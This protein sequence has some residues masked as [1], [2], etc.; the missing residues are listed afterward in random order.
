MTNR[1]FTR[2]RQLCLDCENGFKI[3]GK[4]TAFR[5]SVL[6]E[7][8][9]KLPSHCLYYDGPSFPVDIVII[10]AVAVER[11][12]VLAELHPDGA[13]AWTPL[14]TESDGRWDVLCYRSTENPKACVRLALGMTALMGLP[15]ASGLTALAIQIF[16]PR[17]VVMLGIAAGR[18]DKTRIGDIVVPNV[19]SDYGA[20]KWNGG[21]REPVFTPRKR[22]IGKTPGGD[23]NWGIPKASDL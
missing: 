23:V 22:N 18:R 19:V 6:C 9:V 10:T 13:S 20:G 12:A 15:A 7:T 5:C 1:M 4:M 8:M 14:E 21:S 16:R 2:P 11:E 3:A 17:Q